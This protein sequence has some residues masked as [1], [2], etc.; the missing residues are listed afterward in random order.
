M[1]DFDW[2]AEI[3]TDGV[4][5]GGLSGRSLQTLRPC[6]KQEGVVLW[7]LRLLPGTT[8][9]RPD[10]TEILRGTLCRKYAV[11]AE[12]ARAAAAIGLAKLVAPSGVS[13]TLPPVLT[14]AVWIDDQH[15][16]QV[17]FEDRVRGSAKTLV[18]ELW[19]FGVSVEGL[20]WS[21]LPTFRTE[22]DDFLV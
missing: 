4:T 12:V 9:A 8:D 1:I 6:S 2:Y 15:I 14:L 16:R 20:D 21:R 11:H 18:L 3:C 10:G 17:R 13:A 19:D 7:L 5:F 22:G